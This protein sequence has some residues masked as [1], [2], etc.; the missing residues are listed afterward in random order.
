[1]DYKAMYLNTI[2]GIIKE[3]S[4][5]VSKKENY[6][7]KNIENGIEFY[8]KDKLINKYD[9]IPSESNIYFSSYQDTFNYRDG[10]IKTEETCSDIYFNN[11]SDV[12]DFAKK[13]TESEQ[14]IISFKRAIL[15]NEYMEVA[16]SNMLNLATKFDK[17]LIS[18]TNEKSEY[19]NNLLKFSDPYNF[20][21]NIIYKDDLNNLTMINVFHSYNLDKTLH[22]LEYSDINLNKIGNYDRKDILNYYQ[23][24]VSFDDILKE[25]S[26]YFKNI[27]KNNDFDFNNSLKELGEL[28]ESKD[29]I[30]GGIIG[31][32]ICSGR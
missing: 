10:I 22:T 29:P 27:D 32:D 20:T 5:E 9:Y 31:G 13:I 11:I 25:H 17:A 4:D 14:Y 21:S 3:F 30:K 8:F 2:N 24:A 16:Q 26:K 28:I 1:M 7:C 12:N 15:S 19:R 6:E 23:K 18:F